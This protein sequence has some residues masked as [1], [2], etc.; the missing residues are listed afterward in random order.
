MAQEQNAFL[1]S[2][3]PQIPTNSRSVIRSYTDQLAQQA[4]GRPSGAANYER[5]RGLGDIISGVAGGLSGRK[6]GENFGTAAA[7]SVKRAEDQRAAEIMG[8]DVEEIHRARRIKERIGNIK[9]TDDGTPEARLQLLDEAIKV[10]NDENHPE[11]VRGLLQQ[12][13][14]VKNEIASYEKTKANAI[15]AGV[16]DAYLPDG[17]PMSGTLTKQNGLAGLVTEEGFVPFGK[18]LFRIDPTK[19]DAAKEPIHMAVRRFVPASAR[20]QLQ[21]QLLT[22]YAS[23]RKTNRAMSTFKDLYDKGG[24]EVVIGDSGKLVSSLDNLLLNVRGAAQAV[25]GAFG[26]DAAPRTWTDAGGVDQKWS[27]TE[28]ITIEGKERIVPRTYADAVSDGAHWI[29]DKLDLPQNLRGASSAAQ[30]HRAQIMELAY[31]AAR[32][33]E[34]SNRGLSDNDIKNAL[35]RIAGNT[36]NPQVMMRRF[37]EMTADNLHEI[38]FAVK[39]WVEPLTSQYGREEAE[40]ALV[41]G[42]LKRLRA[43][44][45]DMYEQNNVT[46]DE[47]GRAIFQAPIGP[48]VQPGQGIAGGPAP[49]PAGGDPMDMDDEAFLDFVTGT[50][51]PEGQ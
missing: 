9:V 51:L 45:K 15:D 16:E 32:M 49:A 13:L 5:G 33:A 42:N 38:E 7:A 23:V 46:V 44:Y 37:I 47:D 29:W 40:N 28:K 26:S 11:G 6:N 43:A 30:Q 39:G 24:V 4:K 50:P 25:A 31:M 1:S 35:D 48:D 12:R 10:Y 14:A 2:L 18:E 8:V 19:L 34:P 20:N 21:S 27:G 41:G 17:T 36:S 22:A 3:G